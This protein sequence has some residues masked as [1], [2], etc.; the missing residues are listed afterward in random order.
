MRKVILGVA[1]SLDGFIE[2]PKGEYDWCFTDQDYG[3]AEFLKGVDAIFYGRKSYELM[4]N[5]EGG[6][7][8]KSKKQYV[9]SSQMKDARGLT[10]VRNL[11]Q[12]REIIMGDG[13]N[14][15]LFGGASL[16]SS[17]LK[18]SL[19]DE[20]W[21][22]IHPVI[23][24]AGKPLFENVTERIN[25]RLLASKTYDTGLVSATYAIKKEGS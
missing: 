20:L 9:F 3:M 8:F 4:A 22:A 14:I 21:L 6:N 16:T 7:P 11:S 24:G 12:A 15:W 17:M 13:A 25:L 23:L 10:V 2:G 18:A 1:V 5:F 19:V